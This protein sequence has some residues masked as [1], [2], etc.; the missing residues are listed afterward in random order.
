MTPSPT[1]SPTLTASP[2]PIRRRPRL[3]AATLLAIASYLVMAL[4]VTSGLWLH[5]GS[6]IAVNVADQAFFEWVLAHGARVPAA[7]DSPFRSTYMGFPDGVN[8]MTA[9]SATTGSP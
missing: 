1:P 3:A 8:L 6:G 2:A 4:W 9:S 7:L 5:P